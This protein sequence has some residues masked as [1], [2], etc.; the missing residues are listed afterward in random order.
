MIPLGI[1]LLIALVAGLITGIAFAVRAANASNSVGNQEEN[2]EG[3][4]I[5]NCDGKCGAVDDGCGGKCLGCPSGQDCVGTTCG[6]RPECVPKCEGKCGGP[7][8]CNKGGTCTNSCPEGQ[9][10]KSNQC[11][12]KPGDPSVCKSNADCAEFPNLP[13]CDIWTN[14]GCFSTKC[15]SN[16][17]CPDPSKKF[18][19]TINKACIASKALALLGPEGKWVEGTGPWEG[20]YIPTC[21]SGSVKRSNSGWCKESDSSKCPEGWE[22]R[23]VKGNP[24]GNGGRGKQV[25]S[26]VC[27]PTKKAPPNWTFDSSLNMFVPPCKTK[28]EFREEGYCVWN[29]SDDCLDGYSKFTNKS[30]M[31]TWNSLGN[32]IDYCGPSVKD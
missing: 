13:L 32:Y 25:T 26:T 6:V 3:K 28:K 12:K 29:K 1:V 27:V 19:D 21:S 7:D 10:C 9:L 5:P 15:E 2:V 8:G 31:D 11:V 16:E 17:D 24:D 23:I 14:K 20:Q 22:L 18:C 4:C 30:G